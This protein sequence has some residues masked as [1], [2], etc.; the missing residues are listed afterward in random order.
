MTKGIVY[1]T[2]PNTTQ[3]LQPSL[4]K[5]YDANQTSG[6]F[7]TIFMVPVGEALKT[8]K[9][10]LLNTSTGP[11]V[12]Q[13]TPN[14]LSS[15]IDPR[16]GNTNPTIE[17]MMNNTT[18][19]GNPYAS[20]GGD[21]YGLIYYTRGACRDTSLGGNDA[22]NC[23]WQYNENDDIAHPYTALDLEDTTTRGSPHLYISM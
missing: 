23:Y 5:D 7:E 11:E 17:K 6:F 18:G 4:L 16:K 9:D 20:G 3:P 19:S 13:N 14:S 22:L 1:D 8:K 12:Q 10:Q 2:A 21:P 15:I